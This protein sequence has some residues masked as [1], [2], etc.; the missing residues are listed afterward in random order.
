MNNI[1]FYKNNIQ[2]LANDQ[3]ITK[4]NYIRDL[5]YIIPRSIQHQYKMF[6]QEVSKK[7]CEE[8]IQND[9]DFSEF[10]T[11]PSEQDLIFFR[12]LAI[13]VVLK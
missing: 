2:F 13:N 9:K 4:D 10:M 5:M 12:S 6:C 11:L 1:F 3:K 8:N 7:Y